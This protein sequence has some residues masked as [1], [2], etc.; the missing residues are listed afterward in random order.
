MH[1]FGQH[2]GGCA[3]STFPR[4]V[5]GDELIHN[6]RTIYNFDRTREGF[7]RGELYLGCATVGHVDMPD[8]VCAH[9]FSRFLT[10]DTNCSTFVGA[11]PFCEMSCL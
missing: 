5:F 8:Q 3:L 7:E 1:I 9:T 10:G 11:D 6:A 2:E 4:M